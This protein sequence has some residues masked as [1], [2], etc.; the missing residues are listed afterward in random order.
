MGDGAILDKLTE[1]SITCGMNQRY[2]QA[3]L[4]S[5]EERGRYIDAFVV[6]ATMLCMG[7]AVAAYFAPDQR[8]F[9]RKSKSSDGIVSETGGFRLDFVTLGCSIL[10]AVAGVL[11][12]VIPIARDVRHFGDMFQSWSD[13]RLD[14][15]TTAQDAEAAKGDPEYA[16]RRYRDLLAKKNARQCA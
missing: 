1:L 14:V 8:L 9:T 4:T 5:W 3:M 16:Q 10:A 7:L 11:V 13:L 15:D 12:V 2:A 6:V